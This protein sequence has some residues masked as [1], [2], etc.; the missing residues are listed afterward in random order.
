M[1]VYGKSQFNLFLE[2]NIMKRHTISIVVALTVLVAC[3]A[4]GQAGQTEQRQNLRQRFENMS[5]EEREKFRAEMRER[6]QRWES[7]SD[8]ERE[9]FRSQMGSRGRMGREEQLKA[10]K[11][12][13]GQL[14]RLK[15]AVEA[16]GPETRSRISGEEREKMMASMRERQTAIRAIEQ[17]LARLRGPGRPGAEPRGRIGELRAIHKLAV[18]EKATETAKR[19]EKLIAVYERAS[20]G[21]TG[22]PERPPRRE[23]P[24]RPPRDAEGADSGRRAPEFRLTSFDGKAVRLSNYRGKTVVLEWFNFECPFVV[25][26]YGKPNTMTQLAKKYKDKDVV[27]LAI[28]STSHTTPEA[29]KTFAEKHK[30]AYPILDDRSGRVGHAYGAKT[31]PHMY[32]IDARGNIAYDGAID[33]SP[34]GKT[35][36]GAKLTNYVDKALAE[37]T[38][39]KEVSAKNT[40][41]YGCSVKYPK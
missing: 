24:A 28:N 32:I 35:P 34:M 19:L 41:P 15:T 36:A 17:Q 37:L 25:H 27:W 10:I 22:E 1:V 33:D 3:T 38:A 26:H 8:Q 39:G 23:R 21:R 20:R 30:L 29:N 7:M 9:E 18:K 6:R 13:E 40:K 11:A 31:T 5:E 12:I 14:A 2:A 4:F 16:A